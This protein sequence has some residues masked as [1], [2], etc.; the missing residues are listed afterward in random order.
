MDRFVPSGC[1]ILQYADD[2]LVYVIQTACALV[3]AACSSLSVFFSLLGLLYKVRCGI[4][5]SKILAAAGLDPDWWQIVATSGEF[6][7][8]GVF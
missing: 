1:D 2:I 6:Y 8:W 7:V 4:V 3:Q 5:L